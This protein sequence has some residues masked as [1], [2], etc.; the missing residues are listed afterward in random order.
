MLHAFT[1][2]DST[3]A[4]SLSGFHWVSRYFRTVTIRTCHRALIDLRLPACST[5]P[6]RPSRN[7]TELPFTP[8]CTLGRPV[9]LFRVGYISVSWLLNSSSPPILVQVSPVVRCK[10][11]SATACRTKKSRRFVIC[12]YHRHRS[13]A[14]SKSG[15]FS[16]FTDPLGISPF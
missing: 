5:P 12:S 9:S 1:P 16:C 2:T 4:C 8:G 13:S 14:A 15:F 6:A 10:Y 11:M 7:R 3:S